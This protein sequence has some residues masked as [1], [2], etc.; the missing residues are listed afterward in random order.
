MIA[1][2]VVSFH[3]G[4]SQ[5]VTIDLSSSDF[6][7][8][9]TLTDTER[10]EVGANN[11]CFGSTDS[12]LSLALPA[13]EYLIIVNNLVP[14]DIGDYQLTMF[15]E[16][17]ENPCDGCPQTTVTCDERTGG[18]LESTDCALTDGSRFDLYDLRI[19]GDE[20]ANIRL[21]SDTFSP[22]LI[23][24]DENCIDIDIGGTCPTNPS[25]ATCLSEVPPGDYL[26]IVNSENGGLGPYDLDVICGDPPPPNI[27]RGDLTT[28]S[29][30]PLDTDDNGVVEIGYAVSLLRSLFGLDPR[31]PS[32]F[33]ECA[34]DATPDSLTCV[35]FPS[36][37]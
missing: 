10:N 37:E 22:F 36:C 9:L 35:S 30:D 20:A 2:K 33:G 13:G 15:C 28:D 8:L 6:D 18:T 5:V 16:D 31:P 34:E 25:C 14:D 26:L 12:C 32:P 1:W 21:A 3:G 23:L 11:D 17:L 19:E 4:R 24:L 27:R 7:T 29:L